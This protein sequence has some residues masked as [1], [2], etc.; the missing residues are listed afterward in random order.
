MMIKKVLCVILILISLFFTKIQIAYAYDFDF[1][2]D[3]LPNYYFENNWLENKVNEIKEHQTGQ[4]KTFVFIT[5]IHFFSNVGN[6][7]KLI[8]YIKDKTNVDFVISGGDIAYAYGELTGPS[9]EIEQ[10]IA[11]YQQFVNSLNSKGLPVYTARGNHDFT[12][13]RSK[14]DSSSR[15][16]T[17]EETY[18]ALITTLPDNINIDNNKL[19]YYFDDDDNKT[20]YIILDAYEKY[21]DTTH[22]FGITD[23]ISKD[24]L[25]WLLNDAL[26]KKDYRFVITSHPA[27][28]ENISWYS[29]DLTI[30]HD[31][32]KAINNNEVFNATYEE[33]V[34]QKDFSNTNNV[35]LLHFSGHTHVDDFMISD[36]VLSISTRNDAL[37]ND[38]IK[39]GVEKYMNE[40]LRVRDSVG[41][42][43]FDVV[44]INYSDQKI[45]TTRI[46]T[47]VNREWNFTGDIKIDDDTVIVPDTSAYSSNITS[48]VGLLLAS[49]GFIIMF[50]TLKSKKINNSL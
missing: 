23:Y 3:N 26:N 29:E 16:L 32:E 46:G 20:R 19:Y 15:T 48:I 30:I 25:N 1:D 14:T 36:N 13:K 50:I 47:D 49:I 9:A 37:Y 44:T 33:Q 39:S 27:V 34:Y 5:D 4:Y 35:V 10:S 8:R 6:S 41:E 38:G 42:Q 7:S 12:V 31:I 18:N 40:A 43:C 28:D 21:R 45:Y 17:Q 11:A 2:S 24:Q 22:G